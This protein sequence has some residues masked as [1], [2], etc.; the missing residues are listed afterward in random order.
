ML[1]LVVQ[2]FVTDQTRCFGVFNLGADKGRV[3]YDLSEIAS[4]MCAATPLH[5]GP[6]SI[7][8]EDVFIPLST[9]LERRGY[10]INACLDD[11]HG[12]HKRVA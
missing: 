8:I 4:D 12:D 2:V 11:L 1:N 7:S 9:G 5:D 3:E 6:S 10:Q